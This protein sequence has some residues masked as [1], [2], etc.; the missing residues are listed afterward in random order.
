MQL[1]RAGSLG[2]TSSGPG[3][4]DLKTIPSSCCLAV[5]HDPKC[6]R[7]SRNQFWSRELFRWGK[8]SN[9]FFNT[10][11]GTIF[12]ASCLNVNPGFSWMK[13]PFHLLPYHYA[14]TAGLICSL[15]S[16]IPGL[17]DS[18]NKGRAAP[19]H[20]K[21]S[22]FGVIILFLLHSWTVCCCCTYRLLF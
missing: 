9:F 6:P 21:C 2:A 10:I 20:P 8:K 16:F 11:C 14:S 7:P 3:R 18:R 1:L 13:P 4:R 15:T 19:Q 22:V 12:R 17:A 5:N